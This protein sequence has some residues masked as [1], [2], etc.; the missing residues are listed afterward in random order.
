[1]TITESQ[2]TSA[3]KVV[4]ATL[5]AEETGDAYEPFAVRGAVAS[6]QMT[7]TFGGTVTLEGSNDGTNWFTLS[8]VDGSDIALSGAGLVDF[9]TACQY[10]RPNAGTGVGAVDVILMVRG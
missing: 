2:S 7:G 6:V 8:A 10:I 9:S 5:T 4:W 3:N 1:M